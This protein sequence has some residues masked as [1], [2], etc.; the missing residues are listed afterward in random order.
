MNS[1]T[2]LTQV[3]VIVEDD[4]R[5]LQIESDQDP[6]DEQKGRKVE[7]P[8]SQGFSGFGAPKVPKIAQNRNYELYF[9]DRIINTI[10]VLNIE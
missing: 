9:G 2:F 4:S 7:S 1:R 10:P 8:P 3:V 6:L 5:P